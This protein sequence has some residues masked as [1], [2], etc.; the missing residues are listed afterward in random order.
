M[1]SLLHYTRLKQPTVRI[2]SFYII[3]QNEEPKLW[4]AEVQQVVA[5]DEVATKGRLL[6]DKL[7]GANY[8]NHEPHSTGCPLHSDSQWGDVSMPAACNRRCKAGGTVNVLFYYPTLTEEESATGAAVTWAKDLVAS[9]SANASA[10]PRQPGYVK[11]H[12]GKQHRGVSVNDVL[13]NVGPMV[14]VSVSDR[15]KKIRLLQASRK[16]FMATAMQMLG[17]GHPLY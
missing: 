12:W 2:A 13:G 11:G 8:W 3:M 7:Q 9:S 15:G 1:T 16:I 6:P 17:Q 14:K 10:P 4:I 5:G